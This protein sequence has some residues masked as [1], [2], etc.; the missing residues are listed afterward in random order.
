MP[1]RT[2]ASLTAT[3]L[4]LGKGATAFI[5]PIPASAASPR[6]HAAALSIAATSRPGSSGDRALVVRFEICARTAA[7]G[8]NRSAAIDASA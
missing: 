1:L 7:N 4:G 5:V 8:H 2:I 3:V 6:C